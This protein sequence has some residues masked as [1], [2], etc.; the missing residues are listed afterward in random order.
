MSLRAQTGVPAGSP[1]LVVDGVTLAYDR[2]GAGPPVV[3]LTAI[4]H[5][6]RDF[7]AF[8]AAVA[9]RYEVIRLDWP[10]HGRSGGDHRDAGAARYADLVEGLLDALHIEAPIIVGCSIGGAAAIRI[11]ARRLVSG[12][13]L[14]DSGG[15]V[16]A[17]ATSRRFC[18]AFA[19]FFRA[20][21]RGAWWYPAAFAAYYRF[22][23]LPG[24]GARDQRRRIVAAARETASVTRQAWESFAGPDA[25]IRSLL[26]GLSAPV[27]F[28]WAR[29]DRVIPLGFCRPAIA[30]AR[31]AT[32]SLFEAGHAAFLEQPEAFV[33]G[34]LPFAD[35]VSDL[36]AS[37]A[38]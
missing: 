10:G 32:L 6:A 24:P 23:V 25:D 20:G 14:C 22:L 29:H 34:F 18:A 28:A 33:Q 27:W 31:N 5:G 12:L 16:E 36:K 8:V 11:A 38:A 35:G 30:A 21:E 7:D 9:G 26:A 2:Q 4:Q 37:L 17:N 3:C 19:A 13:V 15:L 1:T